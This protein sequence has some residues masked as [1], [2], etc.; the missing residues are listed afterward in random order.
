MND[1]APPGAGRAL[2]EAAAAA[3][4]VTP[5]SLAASDR[6]SRNAAITLGMTLPGDTVL[7]LLLPLHVAA[8]DV[9]LP[10]AGLLL[11]AN[12]LV[13]IAGYGWVAR[14]YER[15][16]PRTVCLVAALGAAASTLGYAL[17]SG[18]WLLLI[19]R[20]IWGLSFA[21]LNIATQALATQEAVRAARR[22]GRAR[23]IIAAGP[24][25]GLLAGAVLAELTEPRAVFLV[26]ATVALLALPVAALLPRGRGRAVLTPRSR[27]GLPTSLDTWSFVQ[28]L[29]LDGVFVVGLAVLAS[30]ASPEGATL[31]AGA[32]LALRYA[33]EIAL[34]PPGGIVAERC[35]TVR[36]LVLLSLGSAAGLA[37]ISAGYLWTGVIAI[38]LLR[39]MLQPLPAP[40]AA[41]AN[42]GPR[43]VPAIA[44]LATWRGLG[45]GT[46]P[47][48][49]GIV[50]PLAPS[51]LYAGGA[52]ALA[53]TT[54]A[55]AMTIRLPAATARGTDRS[56]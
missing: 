53:G 50:L 23:A 11:A 20:L 33:A 51:V 46:G 43:R 37:L 21:A 38:V 36:L 13:R 30:A 14:G 54:L 39:G 55:L 41:A 17:L 56:R 24:M 34:G 9:T 28:G 15:L 8:F 48:L 35:G 3:I 12:R 19:A 27:F 7:Y 26:L 10:E 5:A 22:N 4:V 2:S 45:A 49:A 18:V 40:V 47:L 25:L 44:R 52:I 29:T 1:G 42:P 6:A 16:G 32:A 31:A